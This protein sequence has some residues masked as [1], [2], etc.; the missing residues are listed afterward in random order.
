M[1]CSSFLYLFRETTFATKSWHWWWVFGEK[2]SCCWCHGTRAFSFFSRKNVGVK[3]SLNQNPF[4]VA[5]IQ[6]ILFRHTDWQTI[7]LWMKRKEKRG[8]RLL[9]ISFSGKSILRTICFRPTPSLRLLLTSTQR[10]WR[11]DAEKMQRTCREHAEDHWTGRRLYFMTSL[12]KTLEQNVGNNLTLLWSSYQVIYIIIIVAVILYCF[13]FWTSLWFSQIR[14]KQ[15]QYCFSRTH[16]H[17]RS[18]S[19]FSW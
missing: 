3:K 15:V 9:S 19:D 7:I 5:L 13:I 18:E 1:C 6:T 11:E 16:G 17:L 4:V 12:T 14:G 10:T 8:I 2:G